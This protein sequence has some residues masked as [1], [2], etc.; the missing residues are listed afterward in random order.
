LRLIPMKRTE[1][2]GV[3]S[4]GMPRLVG[5][6]DALLLLAR[7]HEQD[8]GLAA[9]CGTVYLELVAWDERTSAPGQEW[10]AERIDCWR[11]DAARGALAAEGCNSP[12]MSK[13]KR[14]LFFQTL[15]ISASK[16]SGV[17]GPLRV[18]MRFEGAALVRM[19]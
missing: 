9:A 19:P 3:T 12:R 13:E 14:R 11:R 18:E 5:C 17:G 15:E 7:E 10:R 8:G 1:R 16:S 6:N 2:L 4:P